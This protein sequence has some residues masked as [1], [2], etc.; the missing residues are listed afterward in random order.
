M[1]ERFSTGLRNAILDVT[2]DSFA[3]TMLNGV[4]YLRTGIQP[5]NADTAASGDL[6]AIITLASG[7]YTPGVATNGLEFE[8]ATAGVLAKK[9]GEVWSGLNLIDPSAVIGWGRFYANDATPGTGASTTEKR[10]DF[11]VAQSGQELEGSTTAI[12][13]ATTTISTLNV[14]LPFG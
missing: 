8:T 1:A 6:V 12:Y 9:S 7:A 2:G 13:N 10:F 5:A 11:A 3:T 14:T 4:I